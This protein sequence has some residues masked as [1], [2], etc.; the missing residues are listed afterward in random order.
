MQAGSDTDSINTGGRR[1]WLL[2]EQ[3]PGWAS[4]C[5]E[6]FCCPAS[7]LVFQCHAVIMQKLRRG[8]KCYI[9]V[10]SKNIGGGLTKI[11]A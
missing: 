7:L 4:K 10:V 9:R 6:G 8:Q 2:S 5:R 11:T 1:G 3:G